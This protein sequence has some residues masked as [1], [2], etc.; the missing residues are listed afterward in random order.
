MR[1][2]TLSWK[3][4]IISSREFEEAAASKYLIDGRR[5]HLIIAAYSMSTWKSGTALNPKPDIDV[6]VAN[7]TGSPNATVSTTTAAPSSPIET[8]LTG[9]IEISSSRRYEGQYIVVNGKK[10]RHGSGLYFIGKKVFRGVWSRDATVSMEEASE[11][12]K[13]I[14]VAALA[15]ASPGAQPAS[16]P[17]SGPAP[18]EASV[19]DVKD[20]NLSGQEIEDS[21]AARLQHVG[22]PFDQSMRSEDSDADVANDPFVDVGSYRIG[23]SPDVEQSVSRSQLTSQ[24]TNI[25]LEVAS[26]SSGSPGSNLVSI[27]RNRSPP[28]GQSIKNGGSTRL[29]GSTNILQ[30]IRSV[31]G[32][33]HGSVAEALMDAAVGTDVDVYGSSSPTTG[34]SIKDDSAHILHSVQSEVSGGSQ[35]SVAE[36][37]MD[38]AAGNNLPVVSTTRHSWGS[39]RRAAETTSRVTSQPS[40]PALENR[41]I[42]E[43]QERQVRVELASIVTNPFELEDTLELS[44]NDSAQISSVLSQ[45]IVPGVNKPPTAVELPM[46]SQ[47]STFRPYQHSPG[48]T[49]P[50]GYTGKGIIKLGQHKVYEGE[51]I[52]F[53]G[54]KV[55]HG[56]GL[57]TVRDQRFKGTWRYDVV[58]SIQLLTNA[59]DKSTTKEMTADV[60]VMDDDIDSDDDGNDEEQVDTSGQQTPVLQPLSSSKLQKADDIIFYSND[61]YFE[62][63][64]I[65]VNNEKLRHGDGIITI[66]TA[67]YGGM[68]DYG[69]LLVG[70]MANENA[71]N[72]DRRA[73]LANGAANNMVYEAASAV[74]SSS[75]GLKGK[76]KIVYSSDAYYEGEWLTLKGEKMRHGLGTLFVGSNGPMSGNWD[77]GT[78][79]YNPHDISG[80]EERR[81]TILRVAEKCNKLNKGSTVHKYNDS[82][83][84]EV[85]ANKESKLLPS[86]S[87]P[88]RSGGNDDRYDDAEHDA[89]IIRSSFAGR[90]T[91]DTLANTGYEGLSAKDAIAQE[92]ISSRSGRFDECSQQTL[93]ELLGVSDEESPELE[94]AG[95]GLLFYSKAEP[96]KDLEYYEGEWISV[97]G[98]KLRHGHGTLYQGKSKLEGEWDYGTFVNEKLKEESFSE[99]ETRRFN[100]RSTVAGLRESERVSSY[101]VQKSK[102]QEVNH[103][104]GVQSSKRQLEISVALMF[105]CFKSTKQHNQLFDVEV[106]A[107]TMRYTI[108]RSVEDLVVFGSRLQKKYPHKR[109][110]LFPAQELKLAPNSMQNTPDTPNKLLERYAEFNRQLVHDY[111]IQECMTDPKIVSSQLFRFF[112]DSEVTSMQMDAILLEPNVHNLLLTNV[113][114]YTKKVRTQYHQNIKDIKA[115]EIVLYSF[116][117]SRN[118]IDFGVT[119]DRGVTQVPLIRHQSQKGAIMGAMEA[120]S[121]IKLTKLK[122]VNCLVPFGFSILTPPETLYYSVCV[123]SK[124]EYQEAL[125]RK[126]MYGKCRSALMIAA[127]NKCVY[128]QGSDKLPNSSTITS[129]YDIS[130]PHPGD[131]AVQGST[132]VRL[133]LSDRLSAAKLSDAK[134]EAQSSAIYQA[135]TIITAH[136]TASERERLSTDELYRREVLGGNFNNPTEPGS[137][138]KASYGIRFSQQRESHPSPSNDQSEIAA[139]ESRPSENKVSRSFRSV[140][141]DEESNRVHYFNQANA[142]TAEGIATRSSSYVE[143]ALLTAYRSSS[144][145]VDISTPPRDLTESPVQ[146]GENYSVSMPGASRV[147]VHADAALDAENPTQLSIGPSSPRPTS[148]MPPSPRLPSPKTTPPAITRTM[149]RVVSPEVALLEAFHSSPETVAELLDP[150]D[151]LVERLSRHSEG[152]SGLPQTQ[153][154]RSGIISLR[155]R[156]NISIPAAS[157]LSSA[158]TPLA[159]TVNDNLTDG[160][161][162]GSITQSSITQSSISALE[163]WRDRFTSFRTSKSASQRM[164]SLNSDASVSYSLEI[165]AESE[166][167]PSQQSMSA[168]NSSVVSSRNPRKSFREFSSSIRATLQQQNL[169]SEHPEDFKRDQMGDHPTEQL[170]S[171]LRQ[172]PLSTVQGI[173][174]GEFSIPTERSHKSL[175]HDSSHSHNSGNSS[176]GQEMDDQRA[177]ALLEGFVDGLENFI[178]AEDGKSRFMSIRSKSDRGRS[179][180]APNAVKEREQME[181]ER[182]SSVTGASGNIYLSDLEV[183]VISSSCSKQ[184]V[185]GVIG[186]YTFDIEI[187]VENIAYKIKRSFD[188]FVFIDKILKRRYPRSSA[189]VKFSLPSPDA[190]IQ[191]DV[192]SIQVRQTR[193][194]KSL[195]S[196]PSVVTGGVLNNMKAVE[197]L[198]E[199][200]LSSLLQDPGVIIDDDFLVFIDP[201]APSAMVDDII[202]EP[203][204][205]HSLLLST[206]VHNFSWNETDVKPGKT[207]PQVFQLKPGQFLLWI[208]RTTSFDLGLSV[209]VDGSPKMPF[210][211]FKSHLFDV[212]G[213][214][215]AG[216]KTC[217]VTLTFDNTYSKGIHCFLY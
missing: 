39:V 96:G 156:S 31:S 89:Q 75:E 105:P 66:G 216:E 145:A 140:A 24:Y 185:A 132:K 155:S 209:E 166:Q 160:S 22:S 192:G 180:L 103:Q 189:L 54:S 183:N 79:V 187:K 51:W 37:L 154:W 206:N 9:T 169:D 78:L 123:A 47:I 181:I 143:D 117:T 165:P 128:L 83:H 208:F 127:R 147:G 111:L 32:G 184:D 1:S 121:D 106:I 71:V 163:T 148:P 48:E 77:F 207:S 141:F 29:G 57:Y 74:A 58:E 91:S 193:G 94:L 126:L 144:A 198:L 59:I 124:D 146:F 174:S 217:I 50:D 204:C 35:R 173:W 102:Y 6:E 171:S 65:V 149:D 11:D 41:D 88:D 52:V 179:A 34:E 46:P 188:D 108:T 152:S 157:E 97:N 164:E 175:L 33:A 98:E 194:P 118:P 28:T 16:P 200:Y 81:A 190:T 125:R 56:A 113:P 12:S 62:G 36:A 21:T 172:N 82:Y 17:A 214:F 159:P 212:L 170:S 205:V 69:T 4:L 130:E 135:G 107:G 92:H 177:L 26:P 168:S 8:V 13:A 30:S 43:D 90:F 20:I 215:Q 197:K 7:T 131:P 80:R 213:E 109:I 63:K 119:V 60:R 15:R 3:R 53:K 42:S 27:Q 67:Q 40:A 151:D 138:I 76:G 19:I 93:Q 203:T 134:E 73:N 158:A 182:R 161:V 178:T 176:D 99:R 49:L 70:D 211:R 133:S 100:S 202:L 129:S 45:L 84:S 95:N 87:S 104:K 167:Q 110:R 114:V 150:E 2:K 195:L 115:G 64:W 186:A 68:W 196:S 122:W 142:T 139:N 61:L 199:D 18:M 14:A 162:S 120:T 191:S 44:R 210:A 85:S 201:E 23:G 25:L 101:I 10:L 55:R 137:S 112:L 136:T 38:A 116:R 86:P 153:S 5:K 72:R